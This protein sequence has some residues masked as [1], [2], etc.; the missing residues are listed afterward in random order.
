[1]S[2][3]EKTMRLFDKM[4]EAAGKCGLTKGSGKGAARP[5]SVDGETV[6]VVL[7][8]RTAENAYY[9]LALAL[10]GVDRPGPV[11][12]WT[13]KKTGKTHK[14]NGKTVG[15]AFPRTGILRGIMIREGAHGTVDFQ[16]DVPDAGRGQ[17]LGVNQGDNVTW[18]NKTNR[19]LVLESIPPGIYLTEEIPAGSASSP[20]FTVT[21][22][23]GT[24]IRYSCK[25]PSQHQHSIVVE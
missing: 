14:G 8:R 5:W 12:K 10:G 2:I 1:M 11:N 13:G 17:P 15:K 24:S 18:N 6:T 21:Q 4:K 20:R 7:D 16:P 23:P 22:T 9:A 25:D 3:F 19:A